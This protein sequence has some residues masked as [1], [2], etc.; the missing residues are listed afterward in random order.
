MDTHAT[1]TDS[2]L[3]SPTPAEPTANEGPD[4]ATSAPSTAGSDAK[5]S[6]VH[7]AAA[8]PDAERR[9]LKEQLDALER[10]QAELRRAL[11]IAEHP[12]LADALRAVEG[13]VYAVARAEAKRAQGLSKAEERRRE[14]LE[15]KLGVARARRDELDA[16]VAELE[17][18]LAPLGEARRVAAE[19]ERT[20][21]LEALVH[22]LGAHEGAFRAAGLEVA[23]LVPDVARWLPE[24]RSTAEAIVARGQA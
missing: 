16:Q 11:A 3:S 9:R 24:I 22:A 19:G 17:R 23:A 4:G 13:R 7:E 10:K 2:S 15:K 1:P 8:D 5:A 14:T 20:E 21:A 6:T 12:G 18:E